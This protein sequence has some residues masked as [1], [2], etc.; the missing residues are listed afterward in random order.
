MSWSDNLL[1]ASFR[2]AKFYVASSSH[3][4]GRRNQLHQYAN[5][6]QPYLQDMGK[7]AE[8]FVVEGYIIQSDANFYDY[9][10]ERDSLTEAMQKEGSGVLIHP[11]YGTKKVGIMGKAS[12]NESKNEGGIVRFSVTFVEGGKRAFPISITEFIDKI[13]AAINQALD[14]VGDAFIAA[15]GTAE[16]Y[17]DF[18]GNILDSALA[19][20]Q[21]G[22]ST[23]D[24]IATKV[25]SEMTGNISK[26]IS[27][28]TLAS[29]V[30][31]YDAVVTVSFGFA[32]ASG[33]GKNVSLFLNSV[34]SSINNGINTK[35][36]LSNEYAEAFT[37]TIPVIGGVEGGYS[38]T[39]RGDVTELDGITVP[40]TLGKSIIKTGLDSITGFSL[41]EF[42][43]IPDS[44]AKN[45]A[46]VIDTNTFAI[47]MNVMMV[48]IR[49]D[50]F[51]KDELFDHLDKIVEVISDFMLRLGEEAAD[52]PQAV[53]I[54]NSTE[55][56]DNAD[57]FDQLDSVRKLF[58][59]SMLIKAEGTVKSYNYKVPTDI[60]SA[61]VLAYDKYEDL[62]RADEIFKK[63]KMGI[64][65]PG[66]MPSGDEI[67]ILD[68]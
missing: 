54:G 17:L 40:L 13:D 22:M 47:L 35:A 14:I 66:F 7:D 8:V 55:Q 67:V 45:I 4:V 11:Y 46:L 53:G 30:S 68:E 10:A 6:S 23:L 41:D 64:Q 20:T 29:G 3:Q 39:T 5:R 36:K 25:K 50:F 21:T 59:T 31:V 26:V 49:T 2:G 62:S 44:Q 61:L 51:D 15:Y 33:M 34:V 24:G 52:G 38:G 42:G 9:F 1:E 32:V 16:A 12:F 63:N 60:S 18:T 58:I 43:L 57:M 65:H 28:L 48:A 19:I 37:V 56:I 27:L